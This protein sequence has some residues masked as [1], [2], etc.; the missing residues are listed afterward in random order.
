MSDAARAELLRALGQLVRGL[1]GMFWALGLTALVYLE[2]ARAET[3]E[4]AGLGTFGGLAF[5]AALALSAMLWRGLRRMSAFQPQERIWRRALARA[6]ALAAADAGLSPFLYWWH[7]FP[8]V[9]LFADGAGLWLLFSLFLLA[10]VNFV[11]RRLC[12]MLPDETLRGET[13]LFTACN[14]TFLLAVFAGLAAG[15]LLSRL[16]VL[17][18]FARDP[19][20]AAGAGGIWLAVFLVLLPLAMTMTLVWKIKE[21]IFSSLLAAGTP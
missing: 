15:S 8:A 14:I 18:A 12:A 20:E 9:P 4:A 17:P 1:S 21:V 2:A 16:A 13:K 10:H 6:E 19:W 11:L 3:A 5:F 7:Q